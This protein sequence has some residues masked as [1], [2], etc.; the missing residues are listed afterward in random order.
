MNSSKKADLIY[1]IGGIVSLC[2][3]L[4]TGVTYKI[5]N[6]SGSKRNQ[7]QDVAAQSNDTTFC[8]DERF[9]DYNG[10]C[11]GNGTHFQVVKCG[12]DLSS[13]ED[14]IAEEIIRNRRGS[15]DPFKEHP[16][17]VYV[18]GLVSSVD[19][20]SWRGSYVSHMSGDP[21]ATDTSRDM[22]QAFGLMAENANRLKV[23]A[24]KEGSDALK[25][26]EALRCAA[27][28][29]VTAW[30]IEKSFSNVKCSEEQREVF[31]TYLEL[32]FSYC[33]VIIVR[34]LQYQESVPAGLLPDC[35]LRVSGVRIEK[36]SEPTT[37]ALAL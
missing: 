25:N 29:K 19:M 32:L 26:P 5:C 2:I 15:F 21:K 11:N 1:W 14:L 35:G 12:E 31:K 18:D 13:A 16:L 27:K 8:D 23:I 36:I 20:N 4:G 28:I 33:D 10:S 6:H 22:L 3:A 34:A 30:W 7:A 24:G 37:N 9:L 17:K